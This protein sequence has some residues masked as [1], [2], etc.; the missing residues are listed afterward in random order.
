MEIVNGLLT[1]V[2]DAL[3]ANHREQ[4]AAHSCACNQAENDYPKQA[5]SISATRLLQELA[6]LCSSHG[7]KRSDSKKEGVAQGRVVFTKL[8]EL[9]P[10]SQ[11][12]LRGQSALSN[13]DAHDF[14]LR[15]S[16]SPLLSRYIKDAGE[17]SLDICGR[18]SI[19]H[20]L[21]C[22]EVCMQLN[23]QRP[24]TTSSLTIYNDAAINANM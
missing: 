24:A 11:V 4:T 1:L 15:D 7:G 14:L 19:A 21:V 2:D 8:V 3:K 18:I 10:S 13:S 17:S 5:S 6:F 16:R 20:N 12:S 22:F 9:H 23:I